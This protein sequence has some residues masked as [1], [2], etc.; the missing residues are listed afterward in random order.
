VDKCLGVL[1]CAS[2]LWRM[3]VFERPAPVGVWPSAQ[4]SLSLFAII[5]DS[6]ESGITTCR[7]PVRGLS[8]NRIPAW[9]DSHSA[10]S[11]LD[12]VTM[13]RSVA[14]G[15]STILEEVSMRES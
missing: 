14:D 10:Y 5:L 11:C 4:R 3:I 15:G 9:A 12:I 1:S 8:V 13:L 7:S 6:A 2:L